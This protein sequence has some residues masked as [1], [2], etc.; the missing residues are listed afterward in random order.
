MMPLFRDILRCHIHII[1]EFAVGVIHQQMTHSLVA[2]LSAAQ[3]QWC[4]TLYS[5]SNILINISGRKSQR[6]FQR[7]SLSER[8]TSNAF[9]PLLFNEKGDSENWQIPRLT[10]TRI[11]DRKRLVF[12]FGYSWTDANTCIRS[13][14]LRPQKVTV[15]KHGNTG[16]P[17]EWGG[18]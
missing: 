18:H 9:A 6:P 16:W 14:C 12:S 17:R 5:K 2:S 1:S 11:L 4:L 15:L 10:R 7:F 3:E 8:K 13:P